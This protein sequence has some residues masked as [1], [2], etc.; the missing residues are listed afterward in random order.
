MTHYII[1]FIVKILVLQKSF[2]IDL[3]YIVCIFSKKTSDKFS[4]NF[5][6]IYEI[7]FFRYSQQYI[8]SF[9]TVLFANGR[10]ECVVL[11]KNSLSF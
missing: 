10:K 5:S 6:K 9:S 3:Y 1:C 2:G 11:R 4:K 7:L 8:F